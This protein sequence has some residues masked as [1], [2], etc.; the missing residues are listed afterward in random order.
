[1]RVCTLG[2]GLRAPEAQAQLSELAACACIGLV[3]SMDRVD[4]PLLW[5]KQAPLLPRDVFLGFRVFTFLV[6]A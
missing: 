1:M 6:T 4:A 3:A 2:A 5:N